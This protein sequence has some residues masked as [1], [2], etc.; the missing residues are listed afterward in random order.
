ML[1]FKKGQVVMRSGDSSLMLIIRGFVKRYFITENGALGVQILYGPQD[2]FALSKAYKQLLGYS[3]YEGPETYYYE[4]M[5]DT[6]LYAMSMDDFT[7][8]VER[9]PE[10]YKELFAEIGTHLKSC[11]YRL[12]NTSLTSSYQRVAHELLYCAQE[13][14]EQTAEGVKLKLPLTHQDMADILGITRETVSKSVARLRADGI[15]SSFRNFTSV[16]LDALKSVA[17]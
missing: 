4:T 10:L 16:E 14:G 1:R 15:I 5:C 2:V 6:K 8:T 7:A 12:E 3:L 9:R 17:Y 11:I 13:F